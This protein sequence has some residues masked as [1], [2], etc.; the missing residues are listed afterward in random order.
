MNTALT[1]RFDGRAYHGWQI[2]KNAVS[3]CGTLKAALEKTLGRIVTLH[4][5]GRTD[6][7]VHAE[8]Y[9]TNFRG[10]CPIPPERLPYALNGRLPR[11]IAVL[12]A[13]T[14]PD[15]FH[16]LNS[17][18]EKQY[19]YRIYTGQTRDP[20]WEGRALHHARALDLDAMRR[21]A[22]EFV[23]THDFACVRTLG[24]PVK[25]TV[26]T[27][28]AF[29]VGERDGLVEFVMS[30]NGFLYNMARALAGT[31]LWVSEG[32][33]TDVPALIRSGDRSAAGPVLPPHGLYM[34]GV[35]YGQT[36]ERHA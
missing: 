21:A 27:L 10:E 4:G 14:V 7:G 9:V 1:L 20:F 5:C 13:K 15:A 12:S 3:V 17:C 18:L 24:T 36:G 11:D 28:F 34:T 16:A 8:T 35:W 29:E 30:A 23:G 19:T 25:S 2:Q 31:L 6:A 22:R 26:R 33:V 32:K